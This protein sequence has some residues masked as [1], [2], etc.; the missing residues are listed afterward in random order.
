MW[1]NS[2]CRARVGRRV[3]PHRRPHIAGRVPFGPSVDGGG[4]VKS[5]QRMQPS[6]CPK[7]RAFICELTSGGLTK[8]SEATK[9]RGRPPLFGKAMTP[10]ERKQRYISARSKRLREATASNQFPNAMTPAEMLAKLG[11]TGVSVMSGEEI[12]APAGY[13]RIRDRS[14]RRPAGD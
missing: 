5:L 1:P 9:T 12:A 7:G 13:G 8:M 11:W 10:K 3:R 6:R 4:R 2:S 14:R